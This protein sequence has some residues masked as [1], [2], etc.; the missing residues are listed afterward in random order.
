MI[1]GNDK[2]WMEAESNANNNAN[3]DGKQTNKIEYNNFTN[4][5]YK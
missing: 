5:K 2:K 1:D 3:S 4:K